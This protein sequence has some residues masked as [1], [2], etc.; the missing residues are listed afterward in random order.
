[1]PMQ[2]TMEGEDIT[3]EE[4]LEYGVFKGQDARV[5]RA[6]REDKFST[7][8]WHRRGPH[9]RRSQEA[10]RRS[11]EAPPPFEGALKNHR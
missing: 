11:V 8:W 9:S 4:C 10:Y 6:G 7:T 1:M 3:P 2:V 5:A